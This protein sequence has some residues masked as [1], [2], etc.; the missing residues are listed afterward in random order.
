MATIIAQVV[1]GKAQPQ[2]DV[3]TVGEVRQ[4][5]GLAANYS[6]SVNGEPSEDSE[7]LEDGMFLTFAPAVKGA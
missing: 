2:T 1:G 7:T 3:Q 6:A 4:K 5:L